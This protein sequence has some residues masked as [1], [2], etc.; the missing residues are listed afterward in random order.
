[1]KCS[2]KTTLVASTLSFCLFAATS[3]AY[4]HSVEANIAEAKAAVKKANSVGGAWRDS[5]K[6]IKKA[7]ELLADGN[8]KE[9]RKLAKKAVKQGQLG[10]Q[11]VVD[12]QARGLHI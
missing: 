5:G 9:A 6:M 2:M 12:Q 11:Q 4:A 10:Y 3:P 7:E 1:M 8:A